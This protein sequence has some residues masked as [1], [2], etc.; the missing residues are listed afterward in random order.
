MKKINATLVT[1]LSLIIISGVAFNTSTFASSLGTTRHANKVSASEIPKAVLRSARM[2]AET[3]VLNKT[4]SELQS[5]LTTHGL[6]QVITQEG[7]T[8]KTF[9]EEVRT[10]MTAYLTSAA[11]SQSQITAALNSRYMKSH[12]NNI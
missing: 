7:L 8:P 9:R 5:I 10:E 6:Q 11:Y 12:R 1:V 3:V 4:E 2:H